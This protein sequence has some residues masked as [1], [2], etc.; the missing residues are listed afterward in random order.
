MTLTHAPGKLEGRHA[1]MTSIEEKA[2]Q[3]YQGSQGKQYQQGKRFIPD[4]AYPW[5]AR[6]RAEKLSQAIAP[7]DVVLEYGVGLGWNLAELKCARRIGYDVADFVEPL[8][9]QRG[10]EFLSDPGRQPAN[11]VDVVVCHH[12][13]EHVSAPVTVLESIRELL[14]PGGRLLLFVPFEKERRFRQFHADEPNHHL[15]AW[16]VQTLGNLVQEAGLQVREAGLGAFG[17]ERFAACWAWRVGIGESGFRLLRWV[18]NTLK[19]E[20]EVRITAVKA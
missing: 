1:R 5:I 9:R 13:L 4:Q 17:Q 15:Y 7:S 20:K 10:I 14:R 16:N 2:K 3:R 11:S 8:V 12:T 6:F 18:L 19:Q